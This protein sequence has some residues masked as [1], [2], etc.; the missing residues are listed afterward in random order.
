MMES[1]MFDYLEGALPPDGKLTIEEQVLLSSYAP[2]D[3]WVNSSGEA[4]TGPAKQPT[5]SRRV[6]LFLASFVVFKPLQITILWLYSRESNTNDTTIFLTSL[7]LGCYLCWVIRAFAL[8]ANIKQDRL[9]LSSIGFWTLTVILFGIA[10]LSALIVAREL[11]SPDR[12]FSTLTTIQLRS[13]HDPARL[14]GL[15]VVCF[16]VLCL[17]T[18]VADS[19]AVAANFFM[20][21]FW[22]R[23]LLNVPVAF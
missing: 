16:T 12:M 11:F 22:T 3:L 14:R 1:H 19:F 2:P 9:P 5:F 7:I 18:V 17:W 23:A 4:S 20:A 15:L 8:Y 21:R 13:P 6:V 10:I